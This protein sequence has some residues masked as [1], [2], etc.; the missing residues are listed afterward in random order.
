M[1]KF[2][3]NIHSRFLQKVKSPDFTG[4]ECWQWSGATKGNGYG[5]FNLHGT[6]VPA[7]RASYLL[8]VGS[9]ERGQDVCHTCDNRSCVNPDHLFLGTRK[10][11]MLDMHS[12]GR[13]AGGRKKVLTE[14]KRQEA[15]ARLAQ[16][17]SASRIARSMNVSTE[18]ICKVGRGEY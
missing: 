12:K 10:E 7:H 4:V 16:G 11:N 17:H 1:S 14:A 6:Y 18:T 15:L 9:I 5:N 2:V 13:G 8:F 3:Q